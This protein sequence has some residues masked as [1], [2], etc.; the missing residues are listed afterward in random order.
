MTNCNGLCMTTYDVGL[1]E[2]G[3]GIDPTDIVYPHPMC[4]E[5]GNPHDFTLVKA[6]RLGRL[7]C[8][9]GG[10]QTEHPEQKTASLMFLE[11]QRE[12]AG[13]YYHRALEFAEEALAL[14]AGPR[15][16]PEP[17]TEEPPF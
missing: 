15:P 16:R 5:H 13:R 4:P 2:P 1:G 17:L 10:Y 3:D 6:D 14:A 7:V 11:S 8:E 9:C 12:H